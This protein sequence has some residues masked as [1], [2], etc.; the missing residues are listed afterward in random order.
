MAMAYKPDTGFGPAG[1]TAVGEF[2]LVLQC[3]WASRYLLWESRL[4]ECGELKHQA[5][6]TIL[7]LM[8]VSFGTGVFAGTSGG[9]DDDGIEPAQKK[10]VPVHE[11]K[12]RAESPRNEGGPS[13]ARDTAK[14]MIHKIV[15]NQ[16]RYVR[17]EVP[18][19]LRY[20]CSEGEELISIELSYKASILTI[21]R[22]YEFERECIKIRNQIK[23]DGREVVKIDLSYS[24]IRMEFLTT[25]GSYVSHTNPNSTYLY[26]ACNDKCISRW[27]ERSGRWDRSN[28]YEGLY[29]DGTNEAGRLNKAVRQLI[30]LV[31]RRPP[32]PFD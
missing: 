22:E 2:S 21:D 13:L 27:N 11:E 8:L 30:S 7:S 23:K 31:P 6:T 15:H 14:Y 17:G 24:P 25:G 4:M 5:W 3:Y 20:D 18:A 16:K 10:N 12:Q 32:D 28:R 19:G 26:V 9:F 1:S 29:L